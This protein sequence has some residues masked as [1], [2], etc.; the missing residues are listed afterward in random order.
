MIALNSILVTTD[1][2]ETGNNAVRRA[3]LIAAQHEARLTLL[4]VV[5]AFALKRLR[6]WLCPLIDIDQKVAAAQAALGRVAAEVTRR[7]DVHVSQAVR[8]DCALEHVCRM[9]DDADLLV[10]GSRRM[11]ALR[12][13]IFGTPTEQLLRLVR[14]PVLL[15]RQAA[16]DPYQRVLVAVD[17]DPDCASMVRRTSALA[18]AASLHVFHALSTRRMDRM[19]AGA[20][21]ADVIREVGDGER[22]RA[23]A[24]LRSMLA[25]MALSSAR[26]SVHHGD[27]QRQTL[28]TQQEIAADL[29][30]VGKDG[31]SAVCN[32]LLGSVAQRVLST[33][34]CDVLVMPKL[35]HRGSVRLATRGTWLDSG[36]RKAVARAARVDDALQ[37]Q[38]WAALA[39]GD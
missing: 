14:R 28:E 31:P 27:P 35:T 19:R 37:T 6:T 4:H 3:A 17:L 16:L 15:A 5:D 29:I 20:V 11:N 38:P 39:H 21:P 8:V 13:L 26:V 24:R 1:F 30:V 33:A 34:K 7:H 18:S 12:S 2:S 22:Q 23:L 9:A 36:P 10:I 25:S 32:F